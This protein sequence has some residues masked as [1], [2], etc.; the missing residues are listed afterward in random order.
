MFHD[1]H[2]LRDRL[3]CNMTTLER[4]HD[5]AQRWL[6][7][8]RSTQPLNVEPA[9]PVKQRLGVGLDDR[10]EAADQVFARRLIEVVVFN[11]ADVPDINPEARSEIALGTL[12]L[13]ASF[14]KP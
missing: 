8:N 6:L 14:V 3:T 10:C 4:P 11:L 1:C 12:V 5:H 13:S 2:D 9:R 7:C